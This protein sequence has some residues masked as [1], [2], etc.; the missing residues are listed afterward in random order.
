MA[1]K[2]LGQL[3]LDLVAN[4][5]G[6]TGPLDKAQREADK[7]AKDLARSQKANEKAVEGMIAALDKEVLALGKTAREQKLMEMATRG[8]T[9]AQLDQANSAYDAIEAFNKKKNA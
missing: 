7:R 3:T 9:K 4:I 5:K 8:A 2:S 6:F 1:S